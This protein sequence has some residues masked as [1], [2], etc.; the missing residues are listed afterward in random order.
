MAKGKTKGAAKHRAP[1]RKWDK[2]GPLHM[3]YARDAFLRDVAKMRAQAN[4]QAIA[5]ADMPVMCD[6]AGRLLFMVCRAMQ[7]A[8][9]EIE[10]AEHVQAL[11]AMGDALAL[12]RAEPARFDALRPALLRGMDVVEAVLHGVPVQY[13]GAAA[14]ELEQAIRKTDAQMPALTTDDITRLLPAAQ[15]CDTLAAA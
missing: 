11:V 5:G 1:R 2:F 13:L 10:E 9:L 14:Y 12:L 4:L 8:G 6:N 15:A 7:L 3:A